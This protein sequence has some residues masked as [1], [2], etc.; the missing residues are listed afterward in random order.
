M[1]T[2]DKFGDF[3]LCMLTKVVVRG[4]YPTAYLASKTIDVG[5]ASFGSWCAKI[6]EGKL[7]MS[8]HEYTWK[9]GLEHWSNRKLE[10]NK[11]LTENTV[12]TDLWDGHQYLVRAIAPAKSTDRAASILPAT[13]I[14]TWPAGCLTENEL[15]KLRERAKYTPNEFCGP[16]GDVVFFPAGV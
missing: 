15:S 10:T 16:F 14:H 1:L 8:R 5:A 6:A 9:V 4:R 7:G 2:S 11:P 3:P 12:L 13:V